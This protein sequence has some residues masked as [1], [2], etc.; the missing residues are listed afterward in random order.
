M[1]TQER[2]RE[3][4]D[5]DAATGTLTRRAATKG[6]HGG[7]TIGRVN[8]RGYLITTIE[9]KTYKV[10]RLVWLYHHGEY[11]LIDHV[12]RKHMNNRIENLRPATQRQN[13]WNQGTTKDRP[14]KGV[15]FC[16]YT[17]RWR[18][19]IQSDGTHHC[20]GRHDTPE[21][22]ALAY[23]DAAARLFGEFAYQN[24]VET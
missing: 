19:Q 13:T 23:N 20:L 21:Q 12:D 1:I 2:L 11:V 17:G 4:F 24:K 10:H 6:Y 14:Y 18:A 9:G 15:T 7:R 5:Y 16:K 22:A 3:L 8:D